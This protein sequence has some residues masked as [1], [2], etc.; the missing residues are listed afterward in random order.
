MDLFLSQKRIDGHRIN[1]S[2]QQLG[3]NPPH[4]T[5]V[6]GLIQTSWALHIKRMVESEISRLPAKQSTGLIGTK[7]LD[8]EEL[9][10]LD[11]SSLSPAKNNNQN[12]AG[13]KIQ[14][15]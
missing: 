11:E 15:Q 10:E 9:E 3:H 1:D 2:C 8:P 4:P 13:N 6:R 12:H 7:I 5:R 14:I